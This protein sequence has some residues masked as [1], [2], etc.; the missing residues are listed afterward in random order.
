MPRVAAF[1]VCRANDAFWPLEQ[2]A[3]ALQQNPADEIYWLKWDHSFGPEAIIRVTRSG[4]EVL[5]TRK[6]R[7]TGFGKT[8]CTSSR[9][10][11]ADWLLLE[12]AV[13]AAGFWGLEERNFLADLGCVDGA[14]WSLAGRRGRDYH[15]ARRQSP[16]DA[17]Y[18][19]GRLMFDLAG[20]A[21]VSL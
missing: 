15:Y 21:E 8:R 5:M 4:R 13:V 9:L 17:L 20:L 3:A 6:Y 19:L 12:D 1:P 18:D 2:Y 10:S 11:I 16:G 14:T 7:P